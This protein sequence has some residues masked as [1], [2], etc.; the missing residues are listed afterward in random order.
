LAKLKQIDLKFKEGIFFE[1]L[2]NCPLGM[3]EMHIAAACQEKGEDE[4]NK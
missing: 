3:K 1:D 4:N 2:R